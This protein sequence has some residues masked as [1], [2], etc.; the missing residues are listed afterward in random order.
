MGDLKEAHEKAL[1]EATLQAS[2]AIKDP[3]RGYMTYED[4]VGVW[5]RSM[6]ESGFVLLPKEATEEMVDLGQRMTKQR[7]RIHDSQEW[8]ETFCS[9]EQVFFMWQEM[10]RLV[11]AAPE[12]E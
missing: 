5:L 4:F 2:H 11:S 7:V 1:N 8:V 6:R 9:D 10:A 3:D 12:G